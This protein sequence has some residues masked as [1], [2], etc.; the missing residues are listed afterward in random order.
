MSSQQN[1]LSRKK[2][3]FKVFPKKEVIDTDENAVDTLDSINEKF[4]RNEI[5]KNNERV[6]YEDK[7]DIEEIFYSPGNVHTP[8]IEEI[9]YTPSETNSDDFKG[10]NVKQ[11]GKGSKQYTDR[12]IKYNMLQN[13]EDKEEIEVI[14]IDSE[15]KKV[16][17]IDSEVITI[18]SDI[19]GVDLDFDKDF[20]GFKCKEVIKFKDYNEKFTNMLRKSKKENSEGEEYLDLS[21]EEEIDN[22][23]FL[24]EFGFEMNN[25]TAP[26]ENVEDLDLIIVEESDDNNAEVEEEMEENQSEEISAEDMDSENSEDELPHLEVINW[27]SPDFN[28]DNMWKNTFSFWKQQGGFKHFRCKRPNCSSFI[29]VFEDEAEREF[30][31]EVRDCKYHGIPYHSQ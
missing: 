28:V 1:K 16:I 30:L 9:F 23:G 13:E 20:Y 7:P 5:P 24:E 10:F 8:D 17:T 12:F 31:Y 26:T 15:V 14:T 18:D 22:F 3:N 19:E 2:F 4:E 27:N 11:V 21:F 29:I 25:L 6:N